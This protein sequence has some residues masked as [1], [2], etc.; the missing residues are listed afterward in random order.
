[1]LLSQLHLEARGSR[2]LCLCRI[3]VY[4]VPAALLIHVTAS[5]SGGW[6][7]ASSPVHPADSWGDVAVRRL[8]PHL[9]LHTRPPPHFFLRGEQGK[10]RQLDI[11]SECELL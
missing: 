6:S 11:T 8:Y 5:R 7:A 2:Y 3:C 10:R 9:N 4:N 1:M